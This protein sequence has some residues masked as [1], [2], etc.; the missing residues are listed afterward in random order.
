M[1]EKHLHAIA[2][3][4]AESGANGGYAYNPAS[5]EVVSAGDVVQVLELVHLNWSRRG[6]RNLKATFDSSRDQYM[7]TRI[8]NTHDRHVRGSAK[9]DSRTEQLIRRR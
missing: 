8:G 1:S 6:L 3:Q 5:D 4:I 2:G 7:I 9:F